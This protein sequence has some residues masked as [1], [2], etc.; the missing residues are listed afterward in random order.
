MIRSSSRR[1]TCADLFIV[2]GLSCSAIGPVR[3][4]GK[5]GWRL[6]A[7]AASPSP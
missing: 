6:S 1:A 5:T 3:S 2:K 7:K 4:Y